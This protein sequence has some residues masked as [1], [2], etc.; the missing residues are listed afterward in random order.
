MP[1][2]LSSLLPKININQLSGSVASILQVEIKKAAATIDGKTAALTGIL[3]DAKKREDYLLNYQDD[4][5]KSFSNLPATEIYLS[6]QKDKLAAYVSDEFSKFSV[7]TGGKYVDSL[8]APVLSSSI[9]SY[10]QDAVDELLAQNID[11]LNTLVNNGLSYLTQQG[12]DVKNSAETVLAQKFADLQNLVPANY[13]NGNLLTSLSNQ[14]IDLIKN[15]PEK[16]LLSAGED[17]KDKLSTGITDLTSQANEFVKKSFNDLGNSIKVLTDNEQNVNKVIDGFK[18]QINDRQKQ[19]ASIEGDIAQILKNG[20]PADITQLAQKQ[21]EHAQL[22]AQN[23]LHNNIL[24]AYLKQGINIIGSIDTFKQKA[25]KVFSGDVLQDFKDK[26]DVLKQPTFT[27]VVNFASATANGIDNVIST[28]GSLNVFP[29]AAKSVGKFVNYAKAAIAVAAALLPP[30]P[31]GIIGAIGCLGGLF[32]GGGPSLEEQ[33]FDAMQKGFEQLNQRLDE[34]ESKIDDLTKMVQAMY[35]D[36]MQSLQL[37]STQLQGIKEQ[38]DLTDAM[39]DFIIYKDYNLVDTVI[40]AGEKIKQNAIGLDLYKRWY[41]KESVAFSA[42]SELDKILSSSNNLLSVTRKDFAL[43]GEA[44]SAQTVGKSELNAYSKTLAIYGTIFPDI[45][46]NNKV[47]NLLLLPPQN[48]TPETRQYGLS[49]MDGKGIIDFEKA[50]QNYFNAHFIA[51]LVEQYN[52][53]H[54][55]YIIGT[56]DKYTPCSSLTDMLNPD[57]QTAVSDKLDASKTRLQNLLEIINYSIIQQSI[58]AGSAILNTISNTLFGNGDNIYAAV[59]DAINAN[60]LLAKNVAVY[61]IHSRIANIASFSNLYYSVKSD[62]TQLTALNNLFDHSTLGRLA[63]G[64]NTLNPSNP[65]LSLN[66]KNPAFPNSL[67]LPV[68][69]LNIIENQQMVQS[70]AMME[71]LDAKEKV[72]SAFIDIDFFQNLVPDQADQQALQKADIYKE[73]FFLQ[74]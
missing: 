68:P 64:I 3:T 31:I 48:N 46:T 70:G 1:E 53:L 13:L 39:V 12:V 44:V 30:N 61:L 45:S 41:N 57:F 66:Y 14:A 32:G 6:I 62:P 38:L 17:L 34:I 51:K 20:V 58:M 21:L 67:S 5:K 19:I 49:L 33:M 8:I 56:D 47:K 42:L 2:T 9:N 24:D 50:T 15:H 4:I 54:T 65:T 25:E 43:P 37:I 71:L 52:A 11:G 72:I 35:K 69:D 27:G 22:V 55:F 74:S 63:F 29:G 26:L 73:V 40:E 28:M 7:S 59:A 10:T 23:L 36:L 16:V 18:D 60:E